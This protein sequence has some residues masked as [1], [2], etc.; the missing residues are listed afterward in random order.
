MSKIMIRK[1]WIFEIDCDATAEISKYL[2]DMGYTFAFIFGLK[3]RGGLIRRFLIH[4]C[5]VPTK[6]NCMC[7]FL[8]NKMIKL[9]EDSL[10]ASVKKKPIFANCNI[11]R[12]Y[13]AANN[14]FSKFT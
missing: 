11:D 12:K 5:L 3:H 8:K 7:T 6:R 13:V 14:K 1:F 4:D 10:T 9:A 2:K